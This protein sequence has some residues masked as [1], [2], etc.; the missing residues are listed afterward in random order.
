VASL[1]LHAFMAV[2]LVQIYSGFKAS[3]EQ[4][5]IVAIA[6]PPVAAGHPAPGPAARGR[7][8]VA[9]TTI[10][11]IPATPSAPAAPPV[12]IGTDSNGVVG[13]NPGGHGLVLGPGRGDARIWAAPLYVPDGG[14]RVI[15]MDSVVRR[16][17]LYMADL[18]DSISRN[19]GDSLAPNR[20]FVPPSWTFQRNGHTYGIDQTWMHFGAF[21][22][23]TALL[24]LIPVPQGNYDQAQ[25]W[26]RQMDMR[27]D[28]LRAAARSE[29]EDDFRRAVAKIRERRDRERAEERARA[30][31]DRQRGRDSDKPIP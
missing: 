27:A 9:P 17:L 23:P 6:I 10:A 11:P 24:A 18:M 12:A 8:L 3:R 25:G 15:D 16:R 13:G 5:T 14:G 22:L 20:P 2:V 28:I 26:N 21:K 19:G 4:P 1:A 29:A 31:A 7:P 30:E